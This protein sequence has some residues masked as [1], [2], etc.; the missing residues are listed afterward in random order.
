MRKCFYILISLSLLA[1]VGCGRGVDR[2]LVLA[3]TLMWTAPDSS[4]AILNAINRDSLQGDENRAYHALLLTQARFRVDYYDYPSDSLINTALS[5]YSDNHNREH[6]TRALLYKGAY[7]EVHDNPVEAMKWYKQAE[8]NADTTDY[9]N[10]AQINMRMGML[11]YNNYNGHIMGIERFKKANEIYKLLG[12]KKNRLTA[13]HYLGNISRLTDSTKAIE[14]LESAY[15]IA[16]EYTD[17]LEFYDIAGDLALANLTVKDIKKAKLY[18]NECLYQGH[19]FV[20][21][22]IISNAARIYIA[23]KNADSALYF[24][25]KI[26]NIENPETKLKYYITLADY[27]ELRGNI[28]KSRDYSLLSQ[29]LSDSLEDSNNKKGLIGLESEINKL[30][31]EKNKMEN[32]YKSKRVIL[33]VIFLLVTIVVFTAY[34]YIRR[35]KFKKIT[36]SINSEFNRLNLEIKEA[37]LNHLENTFVINET[38]EKL[39]ESSLMIDELRKENQKLID[40]E[41]LSQIKEQNKDTIKQKSSQLSELV[42]YHIDVMRKLMHSKNVHSDSTFLKTVEKTIEKYKKDKRLFEEL[43]KYID[44]K[45]DNFITE[46]K[47]KYNISVSDMNLI[48]LKM[49]DFDN[50]DI[51]FILGLSTNTL[52]TKMSKLA[53]KMNLKTSLSKY[54]SSITLR[55]HNNMSSTVIN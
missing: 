30:V 16:K 23:D 33:L 39:E 18:I 34:I 40:K 13:L 6:Y 45:Y 44:I 4:L 35:V 38:L 31:I 22:Y 11:Y 12:E 28:N 8:D 47:S 50:V 24:I 41:K 19:N 26:K 48:I 9:R 51:C 42:E 52:Y 20:D 15:S 29:N 32:G 2:R 27:Y 5:H 54:L 46:T 17:S 10:L 3:D 43:Q 55:K 25:N 36:A 7:Y 49:C 14:Y 21:A 53:K 37:N 1:A